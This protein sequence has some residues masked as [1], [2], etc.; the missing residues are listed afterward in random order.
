MGGRLTGFVDVLTV[1]ALVAAAFFLFGHR[2]AHDSHIAEALPPGIGLQLDADVPVIGSPAAPV[3]VVEFSDYHCPS[4]IRYSRET[5]P[6]VLAQMIRTDRV[7][8]AFINAPGIRVH[9]LAPA[10]AKAGLCALQQGLFWEAHERL[11]GAG[12]A[13]APSVD[14]ALAG[15]HLDRPALAECVDGSWADERLR[16]D[17]QIGQHINV[18]GTPTFI[19]GRRTTDGQ[20]DWRVEILGAHEFPQ[21]ADVLN[22]VARAIP[23]AVP[24]R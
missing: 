8:Y 12:K 1:I 21:L 11:F 10:V 9:P 2:S 15:L 6:T 23:R 20:V 5:F 13:G 18:R 3:V 24:A 17:L 4:C 16:K 22:D 14:A 19:A 7:Q